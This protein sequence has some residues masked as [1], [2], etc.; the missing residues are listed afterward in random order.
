M[1]RAIGLMALVA[2]MFATGCKPMREV[3][4]FRGEIPARGPDKL[5]ERLMQD[6]ITDVRYYS[7]KAGVDFKDTSGTKSFKAHIRCVADSAAWISVV[8]ALG[9]EVARALITEDSLKMMDKL[10]DKYWVGSA[11][12]SEKKFGLAPELDLFV[13]ALLG[14]AIGLDPEEKYKSER[15]DGHYTLTSKERRRFRRAAEDLA[16]DDTL[17]NDKDMN[18]RRLERTMRKAVKKEAIVFKYWIEPDSFRVTRVLI[19]DL[20]HDQQADVRYSSRTYVNGHSMPARLS[21]S[22]SDPKRRA[23]ATFELDRISLDGPL[24]LNFRI[25]EKFERME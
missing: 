18:E 23:E 10:A 13:Q 21:L 17:A 6:R 8:P 2:C 4:P 15:E 11:E 16:I 24:Q 3:M 9:I 20:A 7:A 19:T 14:Q 12:Q 25:P 1:S 5:L 22:L